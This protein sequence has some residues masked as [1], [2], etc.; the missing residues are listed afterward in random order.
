MSVREGIPFVPDRNAR[1]NEHA[2]TIVRAA[3]ALL[4]AKV[5]DAHIDDVVRR[6]YGRDADLITRTATT[7]ATTTSPSLFSQ[8]AGLDLVS[9]MGPA[10]AAMPMLATGITFNFDSNLGVYVA[11]L[12]AD[13]GNASALAEDGVIPVR[14]LSLDNQTLKP[15]KVPVITVFNRE[16]TQ[17]SVPNIETMVKTAL[18]DSTALYFDS[19]VLDDNVSDTTRDAGLRQGISE[20]TASTSTNR[21]EAMMQDLQTL[22]GSVSSIASNG[23]ICVVASPQKA[24]A[25]KLSAPKPFSFPL[26]ASS[27]LASGLCCAVACNALIS[28]FDAVPT[29]EVSDQ[30]TLHMDTSSDCFGDRFDGHAGCGVPRPESLAARFDRAENDFSVR[31]GLEKRIRLG[32][33]DVG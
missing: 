19:M 26:F 1:R 23:P 11:N 25:I 30:T 7:A 32:V 18:A 28:A 15:H 20:S 21:L 14:Q 6:I 10:S 2:M 13:K 12:V 5:E 17:H 4:M 24:A 9:A 29:F 27:G 3:T 31:M 16:I 22:I 8:T 33:A